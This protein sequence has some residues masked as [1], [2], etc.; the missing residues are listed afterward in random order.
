MRRCAIHDFATMNTAFRFFQC[1]TAALLFAACG[2]GTRSHPPAYLLSSPP[3]PSAGRKLIHYP[4][5]RQGKL[6]AWLTSDHVLPNSKALYSQDDPTPKFPI[7]G[8]IRA[9]SMPELAKHDAALL[10]VEGYD[11][12]L[13]DLWLGSEAEGRLFIGRDRGW[14][15]VTLHQD[16]SVNTWVTVSR[17]NKIGGWSGFPV[18]IGDP[19]RPEAVAGAMWYKS[20]INAVHGGAASTRMVHD[21]IGKL[22]FA[23]FVER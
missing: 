12:P 16:D 13:F 6:T 9:K 14:I 10:I 2:V 20:T 19:N 15:P 21:W 18:V 4:V 17:P 23:E 8:V 7:V 11:G 5:A 1:A 22:R 3:G